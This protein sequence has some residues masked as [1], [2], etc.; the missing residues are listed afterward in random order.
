MPKLFFHFLLQSYVAEQHIL[1]IFPAWAWLS[2]SLRTRPSKNR[3]GFRFFEGLAPRLVTTTSV[4]DYHNQYQFLQQTYRYQW[5]LQWPSLLQNLAVSDYSDMH[6]VAISATLWRSILA[7][8]GERWT[9]FISLGQTSLSGYCQVA[10]C[11]AQYLP[12]RFQRKHSN[13][14]HTTYSYRSR[15][16]LAVSIEWGS[17]WKLFT[18]HYGSVP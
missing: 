5:I 13:A 7:A 3:K 2:P 6:E 10:F 8:Y 11:D 15:A 17:S 12:W 4:L 18:F 14:S 9:I 1:H 16:N